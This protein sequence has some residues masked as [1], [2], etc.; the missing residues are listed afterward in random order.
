MSKPAVGDK[1]HAPT[2]VG[3]SRQRHWCTH[4]QSPLATAAAPHRQSFLAVDPEQLLM[5]QLM[6]LA[7]QQDV[8]PPI[9]KL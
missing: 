2:L 9:S 4:A 8:Q 3:V 7:P 6:P 1:I 5:I